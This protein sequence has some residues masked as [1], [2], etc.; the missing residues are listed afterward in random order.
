[1][2]GTVDYVWYFIGVSE[3][4]M[5]SSD[6]DDIPSEAE[7]RSQCRRRRAPVTRRLAL[8][9]VVPH[10]LLPLAATNVVES[11]YKRPSTLVCVISDVYI[12]GVPILLL[13]SCALMI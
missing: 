12:C 6:C 1:M 7:T 11:C 10:Y 2:F 3:D 9:L 8:S 13:I 5:I 4:A